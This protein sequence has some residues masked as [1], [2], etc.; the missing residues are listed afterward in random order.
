[1]NGRLDTTHV[2][3]GTLDPNYVLALQTRSGLNFADLVNTL[4][5]ELQGL[6]G[7]LRPDLA[8][9]VYP[10]TALEA[11][12][13]TDGTS[14]LPQVRDEYTVTRPSVSERAL[15]HPLP[16]RDFEKT[17]GFTEDKLEEI[18]LDEFTAQVRMHRRSYEKLYE[19]SIYG[20]LF[21]D[22]EVPVGKRS[23]ALSPG[24]AGSGSGTNVFTGEFPDGQAVPG[25][26]THYLRDTVANIGVVTLAGVKLLRRWYPGPFDLIG[27]QAVID[28]ISALPTTQFAPSG[29]LLVRP[30]AGTAEALV[31]ATRYVGV[32]HGDIRVHL[33]TSAF[34]SNHLA[35]YKTFGQFSPNNPLAWRY[36]DLRGRGVV[37]KSRQMTPLVDA[38]SSQRF[39]IGVNNRTAAV[40]VS[41][42]A[43]GNY[44]P[45]TI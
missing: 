11:G 42:A 40:L 8:E 26:Y 13:V 24:F 28:A 6:N 2:D 30:G 37:V 9:L 15:N 14:D 27:S 4:S 10:T 5:S 45:P 20:R 3:L 34:T 33:A 44:T 12:I 31:D 7:G 41:L 38:I 25:G 39:G 22:A 17:L 18:K 36:D 16:I 43:S 19:V 21:G 35:I 23:T 1:M 32:L 29:S